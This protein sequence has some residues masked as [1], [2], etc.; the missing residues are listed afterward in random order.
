MIDRLKDYHKLL[1][2]RGVKL[3]FPKSIKA[4]ANLDKSDSLEIKEFLEQVS[5]GNKVIQ[6]IFEITEQLNELK[7]KLHNSFGDKEDTI[8]KE[9]TNLC[10]NLGDYRREGKVI[11]EKMKELASIHERKMND[12]ALE[13]NLKG[14]GDDE[15]RIISNQNISFLKNFEQ[16]CVSAMSQED[17]IKK[18]LQVKLIRNAE[19]IMGRDLND[20]E[21]QE[22]LQ[23]K[24]RFQ[25]LLDNKL[26]QG[27]AHI[28][29]QNRI[30]DL[31][32]RNEDIMRLENNINQMHRLFLDLALLVKSQG[33]VIDNIEANIANAKVHVEKGEKDL[34]QA[35]KNL[36]SARK[37]KCCILLIVM[38]IL[39]VILVPVLATQ[40][41][42][43]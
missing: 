32:S 30:K 28:R 12:I 13:K 4:S 3:E 8:K 33:E 38:A 29:I 39:I 18:I 14:Y 11:A 41:G 21:K 17:D 10:D 27:K 19:T 42:S 26:T 1:D 37:K 5:L 16:V 7:K 2:L 15:I 25:Q 40:L 22:F 24:E 20:N 43:A 35:K 31:E 23:N 9:Y 36:Q 34:V 6:K